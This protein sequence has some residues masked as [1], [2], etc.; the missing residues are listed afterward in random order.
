LKNVDGLYNL[1]RKV[2]PQSI[3]YLINN[4]SVLVPPDCGLDCEEIISSFIEVKTANKIAIFFTDP[5]LATQLE[6]HRLKS[7]F[8]SHKSE[9]RIFALFDCLVT[10]EVKFIKTLC[11]GL[12]FCV[13][14]FI[15]NTALHQQNFAQ[16][17][18][19]LE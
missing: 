16:R 18:H 6:L 11:G 19:T 13:F 1:L 15:E 10:P 12:I 9:E 4:F 3:K 5:T 7:V 2:K 8:E 14:F 17:S